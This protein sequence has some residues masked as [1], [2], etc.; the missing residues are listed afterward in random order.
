VR[1]NLT[2]VMDRL[3]ETIRD[4][5]SYVLNLRTHETVEEPYKAV[6]SEVERFRQLSP[7]EL[8][9]HMD[10]LKQVRLSEDQI[11][12]LHQ[13]VREVLTNV[14]RHARATEVV[15]RCVYTGSSLELSVTDDGVGFEAVN[16]ESRT[17]QGLA[18]MQARAAVL[19]G[20]VHIRSGPGRGTGVVL[21]IP[22][23]V[24][25]Q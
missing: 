16:G 25:Q 1:E 14:S 11:A 10:D 21:R 13:I 4:I 3:N 2:R 20:T 12:E 9:L 7:V 22:V 23:E 6:L 17:G 18:N 24:R 19:G 8:R 15:L 5:R